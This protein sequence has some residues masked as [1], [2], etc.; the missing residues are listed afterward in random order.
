MDW[1]NEPDSLPDVN[2]YACKID[3]CPSFCPHLCFAHY[4]DEYRDW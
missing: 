3:L 4:C 1:I 2:L